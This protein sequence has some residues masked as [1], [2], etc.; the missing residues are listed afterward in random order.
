M[1]PWHYMLKILL[2]SPYKCVK[3]KVEEPNLVLEEEI[4]PYDI[5]N[6]EGVIYV[7]CFAIKKNDDRCFEEV[8]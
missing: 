7:G 1:L 3:Q 2:L 6:M 8:E 5:Q 4:K